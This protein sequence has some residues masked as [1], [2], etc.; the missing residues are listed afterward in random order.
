MGKKVGATTGGNIICCWEFCI[1]V[2]YILFYSRATRPQQQEGHGSF[3]EV[4]ANYI[5]LISLT[6]SDSLLKDFVHRTRVLYGNSS[7]TYNMHQLLHLTKSAEF[8][9]PLCFCVWRRQWCTCENNHSSKRC[10]SPSDWTSGHVTGTW[11]GALHYTL[12]RQ[13]EKTVSG[14]VVLPTPEELQLYR[15]SLYVGEPL[16]Y[17]QFF[18]LTARASFSIWEYPFSASVSDFDA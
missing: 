11:L 16:I 2:S 8:L 7:M 6:F 14:H 3:S 13:R 18:G 12:I 1:P 15:G 5:D 9:G 17:F 10:T 4:F